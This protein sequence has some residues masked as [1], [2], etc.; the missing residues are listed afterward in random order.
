MDTTS[1]PG[2]EG[3]AIIGAAGKTPDASVVDRKRIR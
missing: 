1:P 2:D 3:L